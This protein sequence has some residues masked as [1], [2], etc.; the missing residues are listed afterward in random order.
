MNKID[1][2]YEK[3]RKELF[4]VKQALYNNKHLKELEKQ[5]KQEM[6]DCLLHQEERRT[7]IYRKGR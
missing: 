2:E 1:E 3:L 4:D 7:E 6:I 5:I